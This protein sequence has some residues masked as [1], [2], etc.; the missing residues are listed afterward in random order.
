MCKASLKLMFL[1][2]SLVVPQARASCDRYVQNLPGSYS[3]VT[4]NGVN[5][6]VI[7][8]PKYSR[9]PFAFLGKEF[10]MN[11]NIGNGYDRV[12]LIAGKSRGE[13]LIG[14]M[15]SSNNQGDVGLI[16]PSSTVSSIDFD[17]VENNRRTGMIFSLKRK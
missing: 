4:D 17:L 5:N 15:K 2:F 3:L 6:L 7:S 16:L 12:I 8:S 11:S 1:A 9:V 13:C 10:P 14:F